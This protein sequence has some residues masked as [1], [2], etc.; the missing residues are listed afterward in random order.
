MEWI[1][2]ILSFVTGFGSCGIIQFFVNRNDNKKDKSREKLGQILHQLSLF[3]N[4][5]HKAYN[6]WSDNIN[7]LGPLID[8]HVEELSAYKI[9]N[10]ELKNEG[11]KLREKYASCMCENAPTCPKR[12]VGETPKDIE[13]LVEKTNKALADFNEKQQEFIKD[14]ISIIDSITPAL[15]EYADFLSHIPQAY[16]LPTKI[17]KK[18]Y[19]ALSLVEQSNIVI[20]QRIRSI[21]SEPQYLGD[22]D[23]NLRIPIAVAIEAVEKAKI[24]INSTLE[25]L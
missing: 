14:C 11:N 5:L 1:K 22:K 18:I 4:C 6:A 17:F 25:A 10:S 3:G 23:N 8:K 12:I 7:K 15:D 21:K 9:K 19:P 13:E 2:I 16:L 20:S 24:I